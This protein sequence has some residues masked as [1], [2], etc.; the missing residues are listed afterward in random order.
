MFLGHICA[1][2]FETDRI[3]IV[4]QL[5]QGMDM[6]HVLDCIRDNLAKGF[7]RKDMTNIERVYG[8][9]GAQKHKDHVTSLHI[10]AEEMKSSDSNQVILNKAQGTAQPDTCTNLCNQDFVLAL[11]TPLQADMMKSSVMEK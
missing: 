1:C 10:W 2:I 9:K 3:T 8:L 7:R 5:A 11:Q 6:Q 4:G